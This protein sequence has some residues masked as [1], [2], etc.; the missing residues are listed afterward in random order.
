M[1]HLS[2]ILPLATTPTR[3]GCVLVLTFGVLGAIVAHAIRW[4]VESAGHALGRLGWGR[5]S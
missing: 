5:S 3:V 2:A 4:V 1:T